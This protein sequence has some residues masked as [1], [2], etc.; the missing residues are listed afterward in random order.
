MDYPTYLI[1]YGTLGQKWGVRKYQNEDGTWTEEGLRRRRKEQSEL[2]KSVKEDIRKTWLDKNQKQGINSYK[3]I[4]RDS[5]NSSSL[6]KLSKDNEGF[7]KELDRVSTLVSGK[8][9]NKKIKDI[10]FNETYKDFIKN[11]IRNTVYEDIEREERQKKELADLPNKINRL[12]KEDLLSE[13]RYW[14]IRLKNRSLSDDEIFSKDIRLKQAA[15][16]GIKAL[17]KTRGMDYDEPSKG[18]QNSD[19]WWFICEDQTIGLATVAD[20]ANKGKTKD[21][22][23][24]VIDDCRSVYRNIDYEDQDKTGLKFNKG[25]FQLAEGHP[26]DDYIDECIKIA[27]ENTLSDAKQS[28]I[29]SLI[30]SG[31]SQ[32]EVAKMLGV[33]TSTVNK[34]K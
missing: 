34:Y 7:E 11:M 3:S 32:E 4:V 9:A 19:R 30:A 8:Y 31:K 29:K 12:K 26:S 6:K 27:K 18:I 14:D 33:S 2:Y 23:K 5:I 24:K 1:H 13:E 15:D 22:I 21:Q 28:R 25:I 16:T 10:D 20:L 17:E